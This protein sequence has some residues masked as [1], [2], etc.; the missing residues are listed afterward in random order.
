MSQEICQFYKSNYE[1]CNMNYDVF[2]GD[3]DG[4]CA[5]HQL[6]MAEPREAEL[7]TGVKRDIKL[8]AR[9]VKKSVTDADITVLDISMDSNKEDL[10]SLLSGGNRFCYVDHHFAG[11]IPDSPQLHATIDPSAD[12]CTGLIVDKLLGGRYKAWAVVAAF[13]DN[14][15][16][17]GRQAAEDL[18]ISS[19]ELA[20]LQELG[21]LM[22]YNGYGRIV[23]DLHYSPEALYKAVQPFNNP[24]VFYNT[25][26][27]LARLKDGF[28][29]D[30]A[31]ARAI[32]PHSETEAGRVF[33]MPNETWSRRVAGVF[34]NEKAREKTNKANALLVDNGDGSYLVSVRAPLE[35]KQ[36]A[37]DLC[38][39]FPT[40]GGRE[41]AAGINALPADQV[42]DF[43]KAFH[44]QWLP[45][46]KGQKTDE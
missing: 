37:V 28:T 10:L 23:S 43:L 11:D 44:T 5:L 8:L 38:R 16:D 46:D 17:A 7:V 35:N 20:I 2:N 6:R 36:G 42:E 3:A 39:R 25:S 30:M 27:V 24:I 15:Y 21:E 33:L 18:D 34:S 32:E 13:G 26:E 45:E 12:I 19:K 22:N 14:L 29:N 9:L 41:A 40:G 31:R 4:I 1:L